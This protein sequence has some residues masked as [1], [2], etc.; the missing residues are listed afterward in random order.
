MAIK[1]VSKNSVL[2]EVLMQMYDTYEATQLDDIYAEPSTAKQE[3]YEDI[4]EKYFNGE[5]TFDFHICE[6]NSGDFICC[7]ECEDGYEFMSMT[8]HY[9]VPY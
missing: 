2:G 4:I 6:H 7:W 3:A 9:I 8:K 1:K 5:N